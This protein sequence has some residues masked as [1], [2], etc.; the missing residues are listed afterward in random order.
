MVAT[1]RSRSAILSPWRS[2]MRLGASAILLALGMTASTAATQTPAGPTRREYGIYLGVGY[3]NASDTSFYASGEARL[4]FVAG[5]FARFPL[6]AGLSFQPEL[7][8]S[9]KAAYSILIGPGGTPTTT[10]ERIPD[11]ELPL[12]LRFAARPVAG[13]LVPYALAGPFVSLRFNCS[14][15]PRCRARGS[16]AG[17]LIGVGADV[18]IFTVTARYVYGTQPL[19]VGSPTKNRAWNFLLGWRW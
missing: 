6:R 17:G 9:E 3:A 13:F 4:S 16:D 2:T 19:I 10:S 12:L 14:D 8:V 7:T 18:G 11:L 5:V 15:D 1:P